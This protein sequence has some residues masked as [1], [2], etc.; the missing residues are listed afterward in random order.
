M[1]AY[2]KEQASLFINLLT[3][4][5]MLSVTVLLAIYG[6]SSCYS[7]DKTSVTKTMNPRDHVIANL[8]NMFAGSCMCVR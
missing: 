1:L 7:V 5:L 6:V 2:S 8:Q 3:S 4:P